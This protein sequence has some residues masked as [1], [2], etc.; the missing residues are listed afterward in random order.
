MQNCYIESIRVENDGDFHIR[1]MVD[2]E[3]ASMINTANVN[4]QFGD[5]VLEPICQNPVTHTA[6]EI[7]DAINKVYLGAELPKQALDEAA[8]KSAKALGW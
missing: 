4:G 2:S 7:N 1:L 3:F 8:A 6:N 5:L